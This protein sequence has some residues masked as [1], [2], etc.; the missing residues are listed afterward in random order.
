MTGFCSSNNLCG[1]IYECPKLF[2]DLMKTFTILL[3]NR[4]MQTAFPNMSITYLTSAP[5]M[6]DTLFLLCEDHQNFYWICNVLIFL[7]TN[8][9]VAV[10]FCCY[11]VL[12]IPLTQLVFVSRNLVKLVSMVNLMF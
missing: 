7:I 5:K 1:I 12:Q 8:I 10:L 4:N 3:M 6:L 2:V 9:K 11:I